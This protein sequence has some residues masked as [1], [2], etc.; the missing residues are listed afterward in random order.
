[1]KRISFTLTLLLTAV[2][3][4]FTACTN[5]AEN[6]KKK[7]T[8]A[9]LSGPYELLLVAHKS[10]L[11]SGDG[12]EFRNIVE[13]PIVGIPQPE[14]NFRVTALEPRDYKGKYLMYGNIFIADIDSKYEHADMKVET[15]VNAQPQVV[16][17]V[18]APTSDALMIF[19]ENKKDS[20][21]DIF[22]QH[23]IERE[24]TFLKKHH[25]KEIA[26][27]AKKQ[28]GIDILAPSDIDQVFT[29]EGFIWGTAS[30]RNSM[31]NLCIYNY[32]Y[33]GEEDFT[34]ENFIQHRDS[35]MKIRVQGEKDGQYMRTDARYVY[36]KANIY[37][38]QFT[39]IVR[40]LWVME[41]DAMG[42]PFVA[43]ARL[44]EARKQIIVAEGFV[45]APDEKKRPLI[46]ELEASLQTVVL[47]Q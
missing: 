29:H 12:M 10:W 31:L 47:P 27:Q 22:N 34:L 24:I 36:E 7:A 13:R 21:L 17:T 11:A 37:N 43:Y 35:V 44:D 46:R 20:I 45:F 28:F 25:G 23:E 6:K 4:I 42:G 9:I 8:A 30:K 16:I 26:K 41:N 40:G 5:P 33:T 3:S 38:N 15:D 14:P 39:Y 2:F 32:P 1:M 18:K 19:L